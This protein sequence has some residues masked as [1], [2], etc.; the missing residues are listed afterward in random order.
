MNGQQTLAFV[1]SRE[2]GACPLPSYD[3]SLTQ[4]RM[5][6]MLLYTIKGLVGG[7]QNVRARFSLRGSKG[8]NLYSTFVRSS[9]RAA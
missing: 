6:P 5:R 1:I 9:T 3:F 7:V 2:K 4:H 8:E